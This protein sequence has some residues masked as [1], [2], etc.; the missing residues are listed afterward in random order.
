M[1][2]KLQILRIA[3]VNHLERFVYKTSKISCAHHHVVRLYRA[4]FSFDWHYL[5]LI[6]DFRDS[7]NRLLNI[8]VTRKRMSMVLDVLIANP[9]HILLG[10]ASI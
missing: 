7:F 9:V 10:Y 6:L 2:K 5:C 3:C 1:Q 8:E 4:F